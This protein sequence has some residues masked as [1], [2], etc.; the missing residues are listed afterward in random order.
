MSNTILGAFGTA[1]AALLVWLTVRIIN[2]REPW[3]IIL[4]LTA[5]TFGFCAGW[6]GYLCYLADAG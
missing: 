5:V 1:Y 4:A 6:W 2:R 3:A